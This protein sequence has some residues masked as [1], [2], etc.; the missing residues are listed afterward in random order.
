MGKTGS[1]M[2]NLINKLI[3][4]Q[5]EDGTDQLSSRTQTVC[6]YKCYCNGH[7]FIFVDTSSLNNGQLSQ[8]V[9]F[10]AI[11]TWLTETYRKSVEL[12]E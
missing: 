9:V 10:T 7:R 2:S 5:P 4:M 8:C 1:G 12:S 11:A 6:A 3:G